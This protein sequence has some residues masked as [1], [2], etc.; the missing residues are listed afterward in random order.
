MLQSEETR[1]PSSAPSGAGQRP[2]HFPS[3]AQHAD[4]NSSWGGRWVGDRRTRR[5]A[6]LE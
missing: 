4:W 2:R 3:K 6:L 5:N 1:S